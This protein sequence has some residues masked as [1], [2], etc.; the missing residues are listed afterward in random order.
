MNK[1]D[2][3]AHSGTY[4]IEPAFVKEFP[5]EANNTAREIQLVIGAD[6]ARII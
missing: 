6:A 5:L 2:M 3:L 4:A 1:R